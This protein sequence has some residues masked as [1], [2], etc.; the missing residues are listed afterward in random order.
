[1]SDFVGFCYVCGC[2]VCR[3]DITSYKCLGC[4]EK[5]KHISKILTV[6]SE[7]ANEFLEKERVVNV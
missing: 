1:M 7:D 6:S 2:E 3:E 5:V 4:G